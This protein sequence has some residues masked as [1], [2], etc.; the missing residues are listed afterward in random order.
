MSKGHSYK[1]SSA[2][3][4]LPSP[5]PS[6]VLVA[7]GGGSVTWTWTGTEPDNWALGNCGDIS[8]GDAWQTAGPGTREFDGIDPALNPYWVY[9]YQSGTDTLQTP[10]SNCVSVT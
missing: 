8:V 7:V 3:T 2:P 10:T 1:G 6:I 4:P 5:P 9:G